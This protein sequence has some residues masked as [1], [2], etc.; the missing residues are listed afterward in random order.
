MTVFCVPAATWKPNCWDRK[1]CDFGLMLKYFH[2][3]LYSLWIATLASC[4]QKSIKIL[5]MF[6]VINDIQ[7]VSHLFA[8]IFK[9]YFPV[10]HALRN[11]TILQIKKTQTNN[12]CSTYT[13]LQYLVPKIK[14]DLWWT[15]YLTVVNSDQWWTQENKYSMIKEVMEDKN[16]STNPLLCI[17]YFTGIIKLSKWNKAPYVIC[18]QSS[19]IL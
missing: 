6:S 16:I 19:K 11:I 4:S 18:V 15:R 2:K 13:W 8:R 9:C 14:Y 3:Y 5:I 17:N 7:R 10:K 12:Y 1:I